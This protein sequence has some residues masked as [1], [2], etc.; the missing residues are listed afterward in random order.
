MEEWAKIPATVC[1]NLVKTYRKRLT[2]ISILLWFKVPREHFESKRN[3]CHTPIGLHMQTKPN[4]RYFR[5][6]RNPGQDAS[7]KNGTF[8]HPKIVRCAFTSIH[9][10]SWH[11]SG[12]NLSIVG[13]QIQRS[14][15]TKIRNENKNAVLIPLINNFIKKEIN[16]NQKQ[17][18]RHLISA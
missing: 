17:F 1:E 11:S 5:Q 6:Y 15:C 2:R 18:H 3:G 9:L 10:I 4:P 8:G 12:G 13:C 16:A 14:R 7:G